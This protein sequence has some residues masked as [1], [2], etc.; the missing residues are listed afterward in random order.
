MSYSERFESLIEARIRAARES[1]EFDDLPTYPAGSAGPARLQATPTRAERMRG[2][3]HC[4]RRRWKSSG[5]PRDLTDIAGSVGI[6]ARAPICRRLSGN[7]Q[8][9]EMT[10]DRLIAGL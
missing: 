7:W 5:G 2:A 1:G 4:R 3:R 8:C 10:I 6:A 9:G